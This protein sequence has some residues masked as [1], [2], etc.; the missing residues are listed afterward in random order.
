MHPSWWFILNLPTFRGISQARLWMFWHFVFDF[1]SRFTCQNIIIRAKTCYVHLRSLSWR[2][3]T[4]PQKPSKWFGLAQRHRAC[5]GPSLAQ[6]T[7]PK[8]IKK[9]SKTNRSTWEKYSFPRLFG[10]FHHLLSAVL[11]LFASFSVPGTGPHSTRPTWSSPNSV[12]WSH[13]H[14]AQPSLSRLQNVQKISF[15]KNVWNS[16][17]DWKVY[18][19]NISKTFF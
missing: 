18:V 5:V 11:S 15:Y 8:I 10:L 7:D 9:Q 17:K 12:C 4:R 19:Y 2:A 14:A 13:R 3:L 6:K 16:V 1:P